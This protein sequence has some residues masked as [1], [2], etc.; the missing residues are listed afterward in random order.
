MYTILYFP[1]HKKMREPTGSPSAGSHILLTIQY[2]KGL[3][4]PLDTKRGIKRNYLF[5]IL[6]T[7]IFDRKFDGIGRL[8]GFHI[9]L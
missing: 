2:K 9:H 6:K 7:K 4:I 8:V 3:S 1:I 5:I